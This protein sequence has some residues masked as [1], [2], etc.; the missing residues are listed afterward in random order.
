[1]AYKIYKRG[2]TWHIDF[3][4]NGRRYRHSLQTS[5]KDMASK[6]A[7]K[8]YNDTLQAE[9]GF[10]R[11]LT[12]RDAVNRFLEY[13]KIAKKSYIHDIARGRAIVDFFQP[14]TPIKSIKSLDVEQFRAHLKT[15]GLKG[16]TVN[17]YLALL[18]TIINKLIKD[19]LFD[20]RNPV[21]GIRFFKETPKLNYFEPEE[22]EKILDYARM[23]SSNAKTVSQFYFYPFILIAVSTGMRAGEIFGLTWRDLKPGHL[24]IRTSKSGKG[25][26]IP[27]SAWLHEFIEGLPHHSDFV[28]ATMHRLTNTFRKSW[29]RMRRDLK[30]DGTIHTL[31]HTFGTS[32]VAAGVDLVTV[33]TLLRHSDISMTQVYAH[34]SNERM[35]QAIENNPVVTNRSHGTGTFLAQ[36]LKKVDNKLRLAGVEPAAPG[37]G[38]PRSIL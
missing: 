8:I 32:M 16:S 2:K 9:Y 36:S 24:V 25:R 31:R 5:R 6:I 17:R 26:I 18:K 13:S 29:N 4:I 20:G 15:Q 1:M 38:I 22:V 27:I 30:I 37:L 35:R 28:I 7:D 14:Y 10:L 33:K 12:V 3:T 23:I 21:S 19:E 11:D 34:T